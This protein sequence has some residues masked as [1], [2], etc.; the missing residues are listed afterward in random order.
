MTY[1]SLRTERMMLGSMKRLAYAT[2]LLCGC[3]Q[4][5]REERL[6]NR[7]EAKIQLPHGAGNLA[8][9]AKTYAYLP[10]DG[11]VTGEYFV[12]HDGE[13]PPSCEDIERAERQGVEVWAACPLREGPRSGQ[14]R[15]FKDY[16]NLPYADEGGCTWVDVEYNFK[17]DHL[18]AQC[19]GTG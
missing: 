14:R 8:S 19:H 1:L 5:S 9:Y 11:L 13:Q 15:W 7:I 16:R 4:P 18:L 12:P 17:T 6:M 2:L 3:Q 10:A